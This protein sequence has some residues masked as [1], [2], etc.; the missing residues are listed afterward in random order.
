MEVAMT[1]RKVCRRPRWSEN[2]P[3]KNLPEALPMAP[4]VTAKAASLRA[5]PA[6]R[7]KGTS[8]LMTMVPAVVPSAYAIHSAERPGFAASARSAHRFM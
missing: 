2:Q 5:Q 4:I 7:A 1:A 8:W 3:E 6:D